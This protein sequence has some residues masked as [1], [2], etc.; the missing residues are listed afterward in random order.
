MREATVVL[1]DYRHVSELKSR[2]ELGGVRLHFPSVDPIHDAFGGMIHDQRYDVCE[3]AIGAFLQAWDFGKPL[4]LLPV[5]VVASVKHDCLYASPAR[6]FSSPKELKGCRIGVRSYSQTTGL[7]VRAWLAEEFGVDAPD[8]TWVVT[9]GSHAAEYE[10]PRNVV[11][12]DRSLT[13]E[14]MVGEI[15][16]AILGRRVARE[17]P[18]LKPIV[19]D[20]DERDREWVRRHGCVPINHMVAVTESFADQQPQAVEA[21]YDLLV[22]GISSSVGQGPSDGSPSAL[23]TGADAVRGGLELAADYALRQ[24]MITRP[25]AD[26]DR[27]LVSIGGER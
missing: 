14:L 7:W 18:S 15:D 26:V 19:D 6:D 16:A 22:S 12:T 10:D 17:H 23:R 4:R 20:C 9:E 13:E 1:G 11:H 3:L 25:V 21:I 2:E 8:V 5:V 27:L 24:G